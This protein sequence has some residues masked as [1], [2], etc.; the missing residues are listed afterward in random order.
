MQITN[1]WPS[2]STYFPIVDSDGRIIAVLVGQPRDERYKQSADA[3]FDLL[4]E[5][6]ETAVFDDHETQHRRGNFP[7]LNV[8]V[9]HGTGT[10]APVYLNNQRHAEMAER[11]LADT[12]VKRLAA[13]ASGKPPS[14]QPR[15]RLI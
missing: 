12:N 3:V 6:R 7:V 15:I 14:Y 5:E 2:V 8:G 11:L 10:Q 1:S 4:T 13:F 9:T